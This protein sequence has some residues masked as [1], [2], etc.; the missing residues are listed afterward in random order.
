M[1][2]EGSEPQP[3]SGEAL[4]GSRSYLQ[5]VL[6]CLSVPISVKDADY[7]FVTLNREYA[8]LQESEREHLVGKTVFDL[9]P[10]EFAQAFDRDDRRAM[11]TGT[12]VRTERE[13]PQPDGSIRV[14]Q[15]VR[16][17]L[18][19]ATGRVYGLVGIGTDIT[20]QRREADA[21]YEA[22]ERFEQVFQNAAIGMAVVG[23]DGHFVKVNRA[24][25]GLTGHDETELLAQAFPL[26]SDDT[27]RL[28]A[29]EISSYDREQRYIRADA[30]AVWVLVSVSLVRTAQ[31]EPSQYIAQ[32]QDISER[33]Q[34]EARLR[35]RAEHDALT[36][37]HN[38][39]R[40]EEELEQQLARC[41]RYGERAVL[42][43]LDLNG[44]KQLNDE[45]G[46]QTG[47]DA[48]RHVARTLSASVRDSDI[49]ARWGGDEFVILAAHL[50]GSEA[51]TFVAHIAA[52]LEQ[53]PMSIGAGSTAVSASIG[54][55]ELGDNAAT[56]EAALAAADA[57]MYAAKRSGR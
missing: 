35:E 27:A 36:G 3:L 55:V 33:R 41:R 24:L 2:S 18:R 28:L 43:L 37:L 46:H 49:V 20:P 5:D 57:S 48:L 7:R 6:D 26:H 15:H 53:S 8:R 44:F 51:H 19:D 31:D 39:A 52:R 38:R 40:F 22:N 42:L 14:Y 50:G 56:A 11:E 17:P 16:A 9:F 32:M 54:L 23:L 45:H 21:L 34:R 4:R 25:C 1:S 30:A 47:D 12:A 13:V 10:G 29:G